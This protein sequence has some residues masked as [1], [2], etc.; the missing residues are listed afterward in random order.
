MAD[1][2]LCI[3]KILVNPLGFT[4]FYASHRQKSTS[5]KFCDL[6]RAEFCVIFGAKEAAR[7]T[8]AGDDKPK[9]AKIKPF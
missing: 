6:K 1:F 3:V 8:P 9:S 4:A 5:L 7:L 2:R